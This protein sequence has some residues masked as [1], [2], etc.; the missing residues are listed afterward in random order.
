M[1]SSDRDRRHRALL[2][3]GV[4]NKRF[5]TL[6]ADHLGFGTRRTVV[7]DSRGDWRKALAA[8]ADAA[9]ANA[10][11]RRRVSPCRP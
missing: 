2:P 5:D 8:L 4:V 10:A 11:R 3:K 6:V 9:N 7:L 1:P